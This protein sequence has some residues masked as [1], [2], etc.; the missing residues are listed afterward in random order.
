[1]SSAPLSVPDAAIAFVVEVPFPF[2]S[3]SNFRRHHAGAPDAWRRYRDFEASLA[4]L[5][6]VAR[7]RGWDLGA[8]TRAVAE[9]PV[10]VV[11]LY[12]RTTLDAANLPK[13]A[14]DALEGVLYV[15]DAEVI[16]CAA[17]STRTRHDQR[18]YLAAA[19]LAPG[20]DDHTIALALADLD[21]A[22]RAWW[23]EI[24]PLDASA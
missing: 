19:Q 8:T 1:M 23:R 2:V 22:A 12:A 13:S 6:R 17:R 4:T 14:L 9:R 10:V 7:P 21:A 15:T 11:S 24:H 20:T 18:G 5:V 16:A 3:K